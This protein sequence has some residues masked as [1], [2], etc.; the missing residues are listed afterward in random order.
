MVNGV[1]KAA[2]I[3]RLKELTGTLI[4]DALAEIRSEWP[5]SS[6][7]A[8]N[9][10]RTAEYFLLE[11]QD[12]VDGAWQMLLVGNARASLAISRWTLEAALNLWWVVSDPD[13]TK[14]RLTDLVGEALRQDANLREG[15]AKMWPHRAAALKQ[16]AS[17]AR[18]IRTELGVVRTTKLDEMM[19][20]AKPPDKP[21][22]PDLYVH[23]RVCCAAA[24]PGL[25]VWERFNTVNQTVVSI[26]TSGD[27][28]LTSDMAI[29]MA[30]APA[31]WLVS[32]ACSLAD[33]GSAEKLKAW[34]DA[35]VAPL[36]G[37]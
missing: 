19:K 27:T 34:W 6:E 16:S 28:V 3:Q 24:H 22:W 4:Q 21:D 7:Y 35:E 2:N 20:E 10:F 26:K 13:K 33:A 14:Q 31:F 1:D 15:L 8:E 30:A 11:A 32:F 5:N 12:Y 29:W 18:Q 25:K 23:Y 9:R 17:R 36:L 37:N